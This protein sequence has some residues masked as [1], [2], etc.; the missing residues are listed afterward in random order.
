MSIASAAVPGDLAVRRRR[1]LTF[2]GAL[3]LVAAPATAGVVTLRDADPFVLELAPVDLP[4]GAVH[5]QVQQPRPIATTLPR[6][7]WIR[8]FTLAIADADGQPVPQDVLHHVKLLTPDR[9]DLFSPAMRHLL[10]AGSETEPLLLPALFGYRVE[11]GDSVLLSGMV[12]NPT[13]T[14]WK[15]VRIS[16]HIQYMADQEWPAPI[17][18]LPFFMHVTE[19]G[20]PSHYDLPPGLTQRSWEMRPAVRGRILGVGG[21]IHRHGTRLRIEDVTTG[22]AIWDAEVKLDSA[23]YVLEVPR[24]YFLLRTGVP[25]H[26]DRVYRVTAWYDN[27]TADT[28]RDAGMGAVGGIF[29]PDGD[30]AY[31]PI[32]RTD[33][34]YRRQAAGDYGAWWP[35]ADSTTHHHE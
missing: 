29:M 25:I 21:H 24:S 14:S 31:P 18:V 17:D 22:A 3:T 27:P 10:A 23:G 28:L 30:A 9:R 19:P 4:A 32:D 33:P 15:G 7:G 8:G 16:L 35:G 12:H 20:T 2:L 11:A 6:S 13:G 26:P 1:R 5:D 34:V